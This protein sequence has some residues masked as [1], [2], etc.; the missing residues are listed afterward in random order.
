MN[1]GRLI[2]FCGIDGSGKTTQADLLINSLRQN[3]IDVSY[4]HSRWEPFL[5]RPVIKI[6][7]SILN[8][9]SNSSNDSIHNIKKEN[10]KKILSVPLISK[11]WFFIF[12]LDY[13]IQLFARIHLR[14][15]QNM[16]I[17]SDRIFYDSII[18]KAADLG[19]SEEWLLNNLNSFWLNNLFP[20]PDIVVY[21]DC[22]EDIAFSRKNDIPDIDYLSGRRT[23][24]L[25]LTEVYNWIK[26]DGTLPVEEIENC[27]RKIIYKKLEITNKKQ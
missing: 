22:P 19:K 15:L 12:A 1:K 6:W 25:K 11:V 10:R 3:G 24:Y 14:Q 26:I 21:V 7:N 13:S 20:K 27:I 23:L 4:V 17:I 8:K 18:D 9:K 2:V 5:M 16:L